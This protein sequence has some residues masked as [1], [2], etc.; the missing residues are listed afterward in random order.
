LSGRPLSSAN[1]GAADSI[2]R[3]RQAF[4]IDRDIGIRDS[5]FA[6]GLIFNRQDM[7]AGGIG[8]NRKTD[9]FG[10]RFALARCTGWG[11]DLSAT[12]GF[13]C[14][15]QILLQKSALGRVEQPPRCIESVYCARS[16][17]R[18]GL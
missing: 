3:E 6:T 4:T 10:G 8:F 17:W 7:I 16:F 18:R 9:N 5:W 2:A 13:V 11:A 15:W 14:L 12:L 1:A